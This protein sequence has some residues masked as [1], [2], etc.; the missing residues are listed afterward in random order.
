MRAP[1]FWRH[2]GALGA[3]LAP[4]GWI[5]GA[6]T[7]ARL[8]RSRPQA[9]PVPV[10]CVGNLPAGGAGKTPVALAIGARLGG[11]G[12][13]V[14]FLA[15]GYRGKISGPIRVDP[16]RHDARAV[17]DEALLLAAV[18]PTWV[19]RDRAAGARAAAAQGAGLIV[20]DDGFQNPGIAKDLSLLVVDGGYGFGNGRVMP[21][22]PLREPVEGGLARADA[23]VLIGPD[24]TGAL[25]RI[26]AAPGKSI[27]ILRARLTPGPEAETIANKPVVAFA[28]IARPDKFFTT[29]GTLG[30]R[31]VGTHPFPDHYA[32]EPE[33]IERLTREAGAVGALAVTTA[34]DWVRLP[35]GTR[36][37][38][39]VLT[40]A[41]E[42]EDE[43][44]L[45][46]V[47]SPI[48]GGG[49]P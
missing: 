15:R 32:Y 26:G 29:L 21:A 33:D 22:G 6:V 13:D 44:G 46:A 36:E 25:K 2:G 23:V 30:C 18:A 48:S 3:L 43:A 40:I 42:W 34:K 11:S 1:E 27:T 20:M 24:E 8:A 39:R 38:V 4:L 49:D 17:G 10:L 12:V 45:D 28:G 14:H 37:G 7:T 16:D 19:S 5:Y 41:I 47:L 35:A 9:S 31:M